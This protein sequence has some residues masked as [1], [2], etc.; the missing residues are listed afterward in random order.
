MV[1]KVK[2]PKTDTTTSKS[3]PAFLFLG[4]CVSVL[5]V[6]IAV[7]RGKNLFSY[8]RY[9]FEGRRKQAGSAINTEREEDSYRTK[10]GS[11]SFATT[12]I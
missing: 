4:R 8:Q 2:K 6:D 10:F 3:M 7:Y 1:R 9:P 11:I 12:S 5:V